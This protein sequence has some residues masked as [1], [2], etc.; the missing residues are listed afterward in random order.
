MAKVIERECKVYMLRLYCDC[1]NELIF[2]GY[3]WDNQTKTKLPSK[4]RCSNGHELVDDRRYPSPVYEEFG[5]K[6]ELLR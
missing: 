6:K 3:D 4:H 5:E 2:S 1:G